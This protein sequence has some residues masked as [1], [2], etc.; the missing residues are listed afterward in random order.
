MTAKTRSRILILSDIMSFAT[1]TY[2]G[3][4]CNP[5]VNPE[6][7]FL[8][9]NSLYSDRRISPGALVTIDSASPT[10]WY[11]SWL[12]ETKQ[13][14]GA[15]DSDRHLLESVETGELCWWS[16]V[17]LREYSPKRVAESP[18]WRWTDKQHEFNDRWLRVCHEK[19]DAYIVLPLRA[20]FGP[21]TLVTL[22]TRIRYNLGDP[23][24]SKTFPNWKKIT[25]A[26][27]LEYYDSAV[28]EHEARPPKQKEAHEITPS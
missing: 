4:D 15:F 3:P 28:K 5:R 10:P 2:F 11:L 12:V 8:P 16:N 14:G 26:M 13:G 20:V 21:D 1:Q 6:W 24:A 22:G 17:S 9:G 23:P 19:R 25:S 7:S 18:H 27:M